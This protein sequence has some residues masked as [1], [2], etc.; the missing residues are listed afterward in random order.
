MLNLATKIGLSS[1]LISQLKS[2]DKNSIDLLSDKCIS[3]GFEVLKKEGDIMRLAVILNLAVQV[4]ERYINLGIDEEIYYDTMSDIRIWCQHNGNKGLK[5][6][7]W[8]KNHVSFELFRIGRLQ[9]QLYESKN[10]ALLYNKL[11][12]K[13]GDKLIYIHIYLK[14]KSLKRTNALLQL[15]RQV[16]F[17]ISIFRIINMI[18]IFA[19]AGYFLKAIKILW[20]KAAI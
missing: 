3:K 8:L 9:F 15:K 2:T 18:I 13:Y 10:K 19:K 7:R 5:N 12:F 11:P 17:S 20:L 14:V 4:K 16:I 1:D 6:Y